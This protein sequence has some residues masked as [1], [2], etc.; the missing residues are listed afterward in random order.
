MRQN[1]PQRERLQSQIYASILG[2]IMNGEYPPGQRLVEEEM[3]EIYKVS[4]TP[5]REVLQALARDGLVEHVHNRGARVVSF[6]PDDVEEIYEIREV[7]ECFSVRRAVRNLPLN[8]LIEIEKRLNGLNRSDGPKWNQQQADLDLEL[9]R[10][11]VSHSGNRRLIAHLENI[12]LLIH[13]LR[14]VGYR[15]DQH[16][17]QAGTEH[18]AIV[19]ALL[20]RDSEL[21]ERLLAEHIE[22]S[23]RHALELFFQK[24]E[25]IVV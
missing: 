19:R 3:A 18:L 1:N 24:S 25:M 2:K 17:R 4:R 11:I 12:A 15:N 5:I 7:L 8:Q 21:A 10:L 23:K 14:L 16:A 22:N 6:T 13:S 9:H 20:R